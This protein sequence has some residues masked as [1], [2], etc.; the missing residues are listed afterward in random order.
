[1]SFRLK[2]FHLVSV[3]AVSVAAS[4]TLLSALPAGKT[5]G[6]EDRERMVIK[7]PYYNPPVQITSVKTKRKGVIKTDG[8]FLD[9]DDWLK[10]LT[11]SVT[12]TSGKPITYV[13]VTVLFQ[14]PAA[15]AKLPPLVAHLEYGRIYTWPDKTDPPQAKPI[16]PG[17]T[18]DL[19][20]SEAHL[21]SLTTILKKH[22][23]QPRVIEM[24]V[25]RL[26]FEDGTSW[27]GGRLWRRDPKGKYGW[28]EIEEKKISSAPKRA[29]IFLG[30][31]RESSVNGMARGD[32][33]K[34]AY[35]VFLIRAN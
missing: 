23:Y 11:V 12:N 22:E 31:E 26:G 29:A 1:M 7:R 32:A 34:W 4:L 13:E 16:L 33:G 24:W 14:R 21:D 8:K 20:L 35:D 30:R 10:G 3:A 19:D 28:S 6:Q 15:Q 5:A 18:T 2:R 17:V 9:D 25:G 27:E